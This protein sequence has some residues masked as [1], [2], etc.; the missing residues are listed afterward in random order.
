M[1]Y[2]ELLKASVDVFSIH[3]VL[4][5]QIVLFFNDINDIEDKPT[6][7]LFQCSNIPMFIM[8]ETSGFEAADIRPVLN[9][10]AVSGR[11]MA[12]LDKPFFVLM[13]LRMQ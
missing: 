9:R 7:P 11:K 12:K 5:S 3:D 6:I 1:P 8:F 4:I 2:Y 13:P 10:Y